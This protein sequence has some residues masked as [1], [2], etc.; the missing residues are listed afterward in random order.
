MLLGAD[1][2]DFTDHRNL[3][4]NSLKMQ[5]VLHW[6]SKVK[7]YSPTLYYIEGP[8][9]ILADNLSRLHHLVTLAQIVDGKYLVDPALVL[10]DDDEE[11]FLEQEYTVLNY[12]DIWEVLECYINILEISHPNCNPRNSNHIH[13]STKNLTHYLPY[14]QNSITLQLDDD[15]NGIFCYKKGPNQDSW[16]NALPESIIADTVK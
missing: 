11:Y 4:F 9:N 1:I 14:K 3:T 7:E 15:I 16:K 2:H 10:D 6:C 13:K 12:D 8:C 5:Q